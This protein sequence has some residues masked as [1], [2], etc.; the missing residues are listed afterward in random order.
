MVLDSLAITNSGSQCTTIFYLVGCIW[1]SIYLPEFHYTV[2][3]FCCHTKLS[4]VTLYESQPECG[5]SITITERSKLN[6]FLLE[7]KEDARPHRGTE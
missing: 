5:A 6:F 4:A 1:S 7:N 2:A 3:T